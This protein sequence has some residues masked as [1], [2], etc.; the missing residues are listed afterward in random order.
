MHAKMT[1][2]RKK[3]FVSAIEKTIQDLEDDIERMRGV[4]RKVSGLQD[5]QSSAIT[6]KESK[7]VS[8]CKITPSTSPE[9]MPSNEEFG[10]DQGSPSPCFEPSAKRLCHGFSL[11]S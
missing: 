5:C 4:L 8:S 1:R 11:D 2:D 3:C 7:L 6:V 10:M 9:L